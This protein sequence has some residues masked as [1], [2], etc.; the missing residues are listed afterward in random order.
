MTIKKIISDGQIGSNPTAD[1]DYIKCPYCSN[2]SIKSKSGKASC[3]DCNADFEID[4]RNECIF[5][6]TSNPRLPI[7]GTVC[8]ICGLFQGEGNVN[9]LYC[10]A[11][12]SGRWQ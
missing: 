1:F 2:N 12:I 10:G 5:I 7:T 3:P 4:D 6:D 8:M 11:R 9:C